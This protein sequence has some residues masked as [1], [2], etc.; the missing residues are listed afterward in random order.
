MQEQENINMVKHWYGKWWGISLILTLGLVLIFLTASLLYIAET[1]KKI[2]SG[3]L[4]PALDKNTFTGQKYDIKT[5]NN[6]WLGSANPK[7]TIVEFSDFACQFS[8]QSFPIIRE[9]SVKYKDDIKIIY[10]DYPL[11]QEYSGDL[12][13]GAKCAGEQ[14]LFWPMHDKL[15]LNQGIATIPE[16]AELAKQAGADMARYAKCV[17]DRKYVPQI[18]DDILEGNALRLS[19]TPTWLVNGYKIEGHIPLATWEQIID[20]FIK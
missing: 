16:I 6:Y 17:E 10:K 8:H 12:S 9:L 4:P 15:F 3:E 20:K 11:R 5:E 13:L 18:Q 2:N 7:V 1:V 19:G 14:G